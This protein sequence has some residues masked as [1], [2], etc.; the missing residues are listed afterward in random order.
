MSSAALIVLQF[1]KQSCVD[2]SGQHGQ[3]MSTN[4]D[5][6]DADIAT[7]L[8]ELTDRLRGA[9]TEL[10]QSLRQSPTPLPPKRERPPLP[11]KEDFER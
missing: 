3:Q 8:R 7:Q 11:D 4:R 2:V 1:V 5:R 6:E 9:R 10:V